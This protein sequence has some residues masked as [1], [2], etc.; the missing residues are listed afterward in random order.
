MLQLHIKIR[1]MLIEN[2]LW[3]VVSL[4]AGVFNPYSA[5]KTNILLLDKDLGNKSDEVLFD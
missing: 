3:C 5:V 1:E 4:P 2:G